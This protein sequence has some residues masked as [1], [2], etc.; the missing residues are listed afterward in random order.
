MFAVTIS[1]GSYRK[2]LNLKHFNQYDIFEHF[3]IG[4][5]DNVLSLMTNVCFMTS[6]DLKNAYY[7]VV[8]ATK[9]DSQINAK[10]SQLSGLR[11]HC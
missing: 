11:S 3:K 1:D 6:V 4:N 9:S 2:I 8:I 10:L 5:L 7:S